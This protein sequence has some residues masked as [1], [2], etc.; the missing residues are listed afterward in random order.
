VGAIFHG[1]LGLAVGFSAYIISLWHRFAKFENWVHGPVAEPTY[2]GGMFDDISFRIH[3]LRQRSRKRKKRMSELL[4]R[5]QDSSGSL[6]DATVVINTNGT[7]AWF[8]L[9]ASS[10]LGLKPSDT[11]Q[12]ITNLIRNPRFVHF[13]READYTEHMEI[14]SPLDVS[15]VLNVRLS[16]YG[17]KQHLLLVSDVTHLRR[18][19]TMRRDFIANV[20]HELRTPLTV[21]LGYLESLKDEESLDQ[22]DIKQYMDRLEPSA[23]R[24]KSLVE[25]LLMLSSLDTDA[26]ASVESSEV[27]NVAGMVRNICAE[28]EQLSGGR[29]EF[30]CNIDKGLKIRGVDKEIYSA[31]MNLVSN[32]VRYT[33]DGTRVEIL[34]QEDGDGAKFCINDNGP[35]IQPEHIPRLTER[36]YRVDVGRSRQTGGTGLGLAI[37]KQV[38]RRHDATLEIHSRVGQGASFCC[39]FPAARLEGEEQQPQSNVTYL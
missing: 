25:D 22:D 37:V 24:M 34:W 12:H 17:N 16:A 39:H 14:P 5:W 7:I 4:R 1:A 13:I 28:A 29:H 19:M 27:V 2:L 11:G 21:I 32:A 10:M 33:P 8:N 9:T 18:L 6:P 3:R 20:S 36:F 26:P 30:H 23:K 15:K 35:G 31:F 38:L